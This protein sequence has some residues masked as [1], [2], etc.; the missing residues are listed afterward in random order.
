MERIKINDL[1][2]DMRLSGEELRMLKGG[3]AG[4]MPRWESPTG[5][6][7]AFG[8]PEDPL[9]AAIRKRFFEI[10]QQMAS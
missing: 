7:G 10:Q 6:E 2:K 9:D 8:W 3:D 4:Y 5:L 1:S